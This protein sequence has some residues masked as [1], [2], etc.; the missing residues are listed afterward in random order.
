MNILV[1][2]ETTIKTKFYK[3]N[4]KNEATNFEFQVSKYKK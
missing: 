3:R 1:V 2:K 4:I